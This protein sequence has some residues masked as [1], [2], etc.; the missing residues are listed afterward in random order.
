[1]DH[2]DDKKS[3]NALSSVAASS[4]LVASLI[5]PI[6]QTSQQQQYVSAQVVTM[7]RKGDIME[8][9]DSKKEAVIVSPNVWFTLA[10]LSSTL[11][12]VFYRKGVIFKNHKYKWSLLL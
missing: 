12:T 1:M 8:V 10:I 5:N 2:N 6:G 3:N 11:L 7:A 4:V 9:G